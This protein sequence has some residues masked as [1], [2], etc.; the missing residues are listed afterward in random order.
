MEPP[1]ATQ[2]SQYL[3]LVQG[4]PFHISDLQN[5]KI[6][7]VYCFKLKKKKKRIHL[8]LHYSDLRIHVWAQVP[9]IS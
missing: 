1:E 6:I 3:D 8:E 4:D 2:P 9:V 5:C 7:N